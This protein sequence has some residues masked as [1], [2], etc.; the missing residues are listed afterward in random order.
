MYQIGFGFSA[1]H[2]GLM[3]MAVFAGNLLMKPWTTPILRRFGFRPVLLVNG[4]INVAAIAACALISSSLPLA[5]ACAILFVSGLA[6]SMQF[7]TLNTIAFA[8]VP[9]EILSGANTLSAA[10]EQLAMGLGI[11]V[12]A[13][14]W[15]FGN[16]LAP[17]DAS[18]ALPFRIAFVVVALF[19]LLA[20]RAYWRLPPRAGDHLARKRA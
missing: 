3:L 9:P 13:F 14:A 12:G 16:A 15:H 11:A 5:A 19:P 17:G 20:M 4:L 10:I 18:A 8:D 1:T 7:T 2:A 6:R